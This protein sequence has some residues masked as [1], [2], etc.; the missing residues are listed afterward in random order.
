MNVAATVFIRVIEDVEGGMMPTN[1]D[2]SDSDPTLR[3]SPNFDLILIRK[4]YHMNSFGRTVSDRLKNHV[5]V[6]IRVNFKSEEGDFFAVWKR[7]NII[8]KRLTN[9]AFKTPPDIRVDIWGL[10]FVFLTF[11]PLL[12]TVHMNV[13]DGSCTTA[14][15][16]K[17]IPRLLFRKTN[18][19]AIFILSTQVFVCPLFMVD[20]VKRSSPVNVETHGVWVW[21]TSESVEAEYFLH[22]HMWVDGVHVGLNICCHAHCR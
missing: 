19:T 16:Y 11:E 20:C 12:D 15:S 6:S 9:L 8:V 14:R 2:I 10:L 7:S 3:T 17:G 21:L 22:I 13:L 5:L 1:T 4:I 18:P